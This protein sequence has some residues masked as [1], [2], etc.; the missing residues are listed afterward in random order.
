MKNTFYE[1]KS[2]EYYEEPPILNVSIN[3]LNLEI[4]A[5]SVYTGAFKIN[6]VGKGN[7]KGRI[8]QK[9]AMQVLIPQSGNLMNR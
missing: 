7:L 5:F 1:V 4:A 9:T 8:F 3:E 2:E 6:N